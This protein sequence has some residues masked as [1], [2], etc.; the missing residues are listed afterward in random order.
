MCFFRIKST[1]SLLQYVVNVSVYSNASPDFNKI[2]FRE[3]RKYVGVR[4]SPV[5]SWYRGHSHVFPNIRLQ[6]NIFVPLPLFHRSA[7][8]MTLCSCRVFIIGSRCR[9]PRALV[10]NIS[11]HSHLFLHAVRLSP[12]RRRCKFQLPVPTQNIAKHFLY[13]G[14]W[15]PHERF[16]KLPQ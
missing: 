3:L 2:I 6:L 12:Y 16:Y 13:G 11:I 7:T 10:L 4:G 8:T 5:F 15:K 14:N 9:P 1:I